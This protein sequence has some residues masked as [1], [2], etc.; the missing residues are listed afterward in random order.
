[1]D[2]AKFCGVCGARLVAATVP[3]VAEVPRVT[4]ETRQVPR[5]VQPP[6]AGMSLGGESLRVPEAKGARMAKIG[7]VL[8]LD[9]ALA[10]AGVVL[11]TRGDGGGGEAAAEAGDG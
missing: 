7:I 11:L 2:G 9:V 10:I 1:M 6:P 8:A 3:P 5:V 4:A